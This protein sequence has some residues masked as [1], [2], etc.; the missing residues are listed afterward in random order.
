[1]EIM[2]ASGSWMHDVQAS[3]PWGGLRNATSCVSEP[4]RLETGPSL[5]Q[6]AHLRV[7]ARAPR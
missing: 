2:R 4:E 7:P 5:Y 1:M 6:T 3:G